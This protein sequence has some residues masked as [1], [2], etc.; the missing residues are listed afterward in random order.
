MACHQDEAQLSIVDSAAISSESNT[1]YNHCKIEN[2]DD[3]ATLIRLCRKGDIDSVQRIIQQHTGESILKRATS[4]VVCPLG[5]AILSKNKE[6][7]QLIVQHD[8]DQLYW[9]NE[10]GENLLFNCALSGQVDIFE[11]L[12]HVGQLDYLHADKDGNSPIFFAAARGHLDIVAWIYQRYP[13][14]LRYSNYLRQSFACIA[15][16]KGR[17]NIVKWLIERKV[18]LSNFFITS[19]SPFLCACRAGRQEIVMYLVDR[20]IDLEPYR[21]A[22]TEKG[23]N[24]LAACAVGGHDD[25]VSFFLNHHIFQVRS[26]SD[27]IDKSISAGFPN[28]AVQIFNWLQLHQKQQRVKKQNDSDLLQ[29]DFASLILAS[30]IRRGCTKQAQHLLD[31]YSQIEP[32]SHGLQKFLLHAIHFSDCRM[33]K[34]VVNKDIE[35]REKRS[36]ALQTIRRLSLGN[37]VSLYDTPAARALTES[38]CAGEYMR[39][40]SY[41][42][43]RL[44]RFAFLQWIIQT[45]R[46]PRTAFIWDTG[47]VVHVATRTCNA[48]AVAFFVENMDLSCD[49]EDKRGNRPLHYAARFGHTDICR[50]LIIRGAEIDARN[51]SQRQPLGLALVH[52]NDDAAQI[53]REAEYLSP[54]HIALA[55]YMFSFLASLLR[56]GYVNPE[57]AIIQPHYGGITPTFTRLVL[58][59]MRSPVV[60]HAFWFDPCFCSADYDAVVK[61][62]ASRYGVS[63]GS[64]KLTCSKHN[65]DFFTRSNAISTSDKDT[66]Q[67]KVTLAANGEHIPIPHSLHDNPEHSITVWDNKYIPIASSLLNV[68]AGPFYRDQDED[69]RN[70]FALRFALTLSQPWSPNSHWLYSRPH[71]RLIFEILLCFC[72]SKWTHVCDDTIFSILRCITRKAGRGF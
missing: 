27:A 47:T 36:F 70:L 15:C 43:L 23:S 3:V 63:V 10:Y 55:G 31:W 11:W 52:G 65:H 62:L 16:I 32:F 46:L 39:L 29:F 41:E 45:L 24:A 60:A 56:S 57:E 8:H 17:M 30:L 66:Y 68:V 61:N 18:D 25:L 44:N 50:Y 72:H 1:P 2:E 54:I 21:P 48:E 51:H 64:T 35:L 4:T 12:V 49:E 58:N 37:R 40:L 71:R 38:L 14:I 19:E 22:F 6:I 69:Q 33:V 53:L 7:C 20:D 28:I 42:A 67:S 13:R 59:V 26:Y 34:W 5:E 9:Q